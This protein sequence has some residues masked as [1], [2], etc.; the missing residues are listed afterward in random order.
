MHMEDKRHTVDRSAPAS[1]WMLA[2]LLTAA[3]CKSSESADKSAAQPAA[4]KSSE[5]AAST[6]PAPVAAP[7]PAEQPATDEMPQ[8]VLFVRI[9]NKL[10]AKEMD[11]RLAERKPKF[12]AV[13]GLA[14][15]VYGRDPATGDVAGIYFF[16]NK[17][18]LGKFKDSEL[19]KTIPAA[20]EAIDVRREVY[21]V[22][23]TLRPTRGPFDGDHK[24]G[25]CPPNI[26]FVRIK[27][28]LDQQEMDRRL[29]E[30][31]P[32]FLDVPGLSQKIYVRDPATGEVAGIYFFENKEALAKFK[33]SELAKT[34]PTAYAATDV[35][36]ELYQVIYPLRAERGP[37]ITDASR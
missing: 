15:K 22:I 18:A 25:T 30:R 14:Q 20:Y 27:N 33:D 17:E 8:V 28:K 5:A 13:P 21:D 34:I 19:A 35:R 32:K 3:A 23:G 11:R 2:L 10:D 12:L 1:R 24:P 4:A 31:K 9:H 37:F 16:E 6:T 29:A 36:R 26:L 7:V